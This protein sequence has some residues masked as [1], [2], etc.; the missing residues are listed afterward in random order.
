MTEDQDNELEGRKTNYPGWTKG[1]KLKRKKFADPQKTWVTIENSL[2][3]MS[4]KNQK[5]GEKC[6]TKEKSFWRKCIW[7]KTLHIWGEKHKHT[8]SKS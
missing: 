4:L 5:R 3:F 1:K 6:S 8:N 2:T 7:G